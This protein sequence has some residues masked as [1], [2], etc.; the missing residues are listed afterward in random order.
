VPRCPG[1]GGGRKDG[2][3]KKASSEG[4]FPGGEAFMN[5]EAHFPKEEGESR[6]TVVGRW[7]WHHKLKE[8]TGGLFRR[9]GEEKRPG[10]AAERGWHRMRR[11]AID[12][13]RAGQGDSGDGPRHSD[14]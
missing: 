9:V 8:A 7:W 11:V 6:R 5:H 1:L 2:G 14:E 12:V 10:A 3:D 13:A 4:Q